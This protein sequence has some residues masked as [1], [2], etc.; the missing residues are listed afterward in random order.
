MAFTANNTIRINSRFT[1]PDGIGSSSQP[2]D[3]TYQLIL[4]DG[5][6]ANQADLQYAQTATIASSANLDIDLTSVEDAFGNAL[7]A[8]ELVQVVIVSAS[9][10]TTNLTTGGSG[11]DFA[12]L[13]A[14]TITPGG[15]V[16]LANGGLSGIGSVTDGTADTIRIANAAGASASVDIYI[17]ARSA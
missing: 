8:A 11:S 4:A 3:T 1:D 15:M 5:T 7:G 9:A 10:N 14:L 2:V 16:N 17:V 13:P 6:G 12:G